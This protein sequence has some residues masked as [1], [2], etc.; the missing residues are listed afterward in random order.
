MAHELEVI[1][2][3]RLTISEKGVRYYEDRFRI[4]TDAPT[5]YRCTMEIGGFRNVS[6]TDMNN[7][8][9]HSSIG[10]FGFEISTKC[11]EADQL[12]VSHNLVLEAQ[13]VIDSLREMSSKA[14][15]QLKKMVAKAKQDGKKRKEKV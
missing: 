3:M 9:R 8:R 2:F 4:L 5:R 6:K 7:I 15:A 10:F 12:S 14:D 11:F 13:K 1:I